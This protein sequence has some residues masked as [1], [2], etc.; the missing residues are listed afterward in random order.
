VIE[1]HKH[2]GEFIYIK[3]DVPHEVFY[4]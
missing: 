3:P 4:E 1:T 2:A